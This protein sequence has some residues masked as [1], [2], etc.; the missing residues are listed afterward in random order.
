MDKH[1]LMLG[2]MGFALATMNIAQ[3]D[4][5]TGPTRAPAVFVLARKGTVTLAEALPAVSRVVQLTPEGQAY[6]RAHGGPGHTKDFDGLCTEL[7]SLKII[8]SG[9]RAERNASL[10]RGRLAYMVCS[11]LKIQPGLLTGLF[12][13]SERYAHRELAHREVMAGGPDGK[14]VTGSELVSVLSRAAMRLTQEA[15]PVI[16]DDEYH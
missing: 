7:V 2:L 11:V 8:P 14:F 10:T 13:M 16:E 3:V 15:E 6:A 4:P 1:K 12:G 5:D 9:W